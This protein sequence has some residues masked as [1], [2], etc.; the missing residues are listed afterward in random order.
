VHQNYALDMLDLKFGKIDDGAMV[1]SK[2]G[3]KAAQPAAIMEAA[4]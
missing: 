1:F 2:K 4:E 3:A